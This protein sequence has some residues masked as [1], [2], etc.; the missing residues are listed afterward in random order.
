MNITLMAILSL[1]FVA[2]AFADYV[3]TRR[4]QAR[5]EVEGNPLARKFGIVPVK[6]IFT[7][8]V[9]TIAWFAMPHYGYGYAAPW[10][11]IMGTAANLF[12]WFWNRD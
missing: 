9:L 3:S 11:L 8:I 2:S 6:V 4:F 7:I 10:V 1:L 12:A 5:G